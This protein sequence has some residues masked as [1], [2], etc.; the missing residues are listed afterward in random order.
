MKNFE[1]SCIVQKET[2]IGGLLRAV[3]QTQKYHRAHDSNPRTHSKPRTLWSRPN[4]GPIFS[5]HQ[6]QAEVF[7]K[8]LLEKT[9]TKKY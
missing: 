9:K 5:G 6:Y 8:T 7:G 1:R 4:G 3:L 2:Q